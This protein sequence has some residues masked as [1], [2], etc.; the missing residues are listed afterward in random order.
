MKPVKRTLLPDTITI[1]NKF[2]DPNT[3]KNVTFR[4]FLRFTRFMSQKSGI[5][6]STLGATRIYDTVILLDHG[7]TMKGQKYSTE[8]YTLDGSGKR[9]K[10]PYV[11]PSAWKAAANKDAVW[12]IQ[13]ADYVLR[14]ECPVTI[15]PGKEADITNL[16][17][18]LVKEIVPEYDKDGSIHHFEVRLV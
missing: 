5:I 14:G 16:L 17:P 9:L 12:T 13:E 11:E 1:Y 10:K 8:G 2:K 6:A 4:T 3:G 15:P 7:L 18:F